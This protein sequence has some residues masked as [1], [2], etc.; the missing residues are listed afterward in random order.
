MYIYRILQNK[1]NGQKYG[2]LAS[3]LSHDLLMSV[4]NSY[5]LSTDDLQVFMCT[6]SHL[7]MELTG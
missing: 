7:D 2:T 5:M 3:D 4:D 6:V 1:Q